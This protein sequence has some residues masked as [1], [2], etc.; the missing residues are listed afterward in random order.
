MAK[1]GLYQTPDYSRRAQQH[2]KTALSGY[3]RAA[4]QPL[5]KDPV[6]KTAGGAL[7]STAAM[8]AAGASVGSTLGASVGSGAS[9]GSAGGW[10]GA[11]IGAVVGLGA[12]LLS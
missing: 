4:N 5:E 12:Y 10:W 8:S 7:K 9:A 6:G 2:Y 3:G 1:V 11:G